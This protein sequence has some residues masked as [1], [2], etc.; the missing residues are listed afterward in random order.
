[1]SRRLVLNKEQLWLMIV[2][3]IIVVSDDTLW[4]GT[5]SNNKFILFKYLL[6]ILTTIIIGVMNYRIF[7]L[8]CASNAY[9]ICLSMSTIVI[10]SCFL[11][12]DLRI[13]YFYKCIIFILAY[14]LTTTLTI[15]RF[16]V[17]FEKI[18]F[19]LTL[20][21]VV[22][23]AVAAVSRTVF[24]LFPM[25]TNSANT[26]F[27][28]AIIF[29]LPTS[30]LMFR[31]FGIFR[32]PGVF[33]VYIIVALIFHLYY[34]GRNKTS[35]LVIYILGVILTFST[36]GYIALAVA[37]ILYLIKD[38][39]VDNKKIATVVLLV[40]GL[41]LLVTQTTLLSKE[42]II[43]NKFFNT[44]RHTTI[45]RFSSITSNIEIWM[46]S[47]IWGAGLQK[48]NDLF[49]ILSY[50]KYGYASEHNTNTLLN[51]LASYGII[52]VVFLVIGYI[53]FCKKLSVR[54]VEQALV[55]IILFILSCG[56]K[57]TFSPI[58][59]ILLFYGLKLD[60]ICESEQSY[61]RSY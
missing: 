2:G 56:E 5:N 58:V 6:L 18:M 50:Q 26:T 46:Q 27:H 53:K 31:N 52:Y 55:L 40:I 36:T 61:G 32:E 28:N 30:S 37:L 48:V 38:N 24:S 34:S 35:H 60:Y 43:F 1:M 33:Q 42:G 47:P 29:M 57:L 41:L 21:S 14:E 12:N 54:K 3:F 49:P 16:A 11:N 51:E 15:E 59:Y 8:R 9:V 7:N 20:V 23:M 10:A 17:L 44:N 22:G 4:F 19:F 13:G 45:A 25:F 39:K